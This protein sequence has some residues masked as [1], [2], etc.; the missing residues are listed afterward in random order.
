MSN[1]QLLPEGQQFHPKFICLWNWKMW[2]SLTVLGKVLCFSPKKELLDFTDNVKCC[3]RKQRLAYQ[4]T[5]VGWGY[6]WIVRDQ[7]NLVLQFQV[8]SKSLLWSKRVHFWIVNI[9]P[10]PVP[11]FPP[12]GQEDGHL[13][14]L[15]VW[16]VSSTEMQVT[17]KIWFGNWQSYVNLHNS[18]Y[19]PKILR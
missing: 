8:I 15:S 11:I 1:M 16:R 13:A 4:S 10:F 3:H 5:D 12:S 19:V 9:H 14:M 7:P 17:T 2:H 18:S 6:K